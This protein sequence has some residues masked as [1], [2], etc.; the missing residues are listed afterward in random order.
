MSA[1]LCSDPKVYSVLLHSAELSP[2]F[3]L[4]SS[5]TSLHVHTP[6]SP[7]PSI[8][9]DVSCFPSLAPSVFFSSRHQVRSSCSPS[10]PFNSVNLIFWLWSH[11]RSPL[12]ALYNLP[13]S[14]SG[15]RPKSPKAFTPLFS[16]FISKRTNWLALMSFVK[17]FQSGMGQ[18][19]DPWWGVLVSSFTNYSSQGSPEQHI[20]ITSSLP[21]INHNS[22][23]QTPT[24][25]LSP[26]VPASR[27]TI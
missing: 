23:T 12:L 2:I 13:R 5:L 20:N 10:N 9:P 25:T 16:P 4:P 17:S 6:G 27:W 26:P 14:H 11:C 3:L 24:L 21:P 22:S 1:L 18:R 7:H 8:S 15:L 19:A